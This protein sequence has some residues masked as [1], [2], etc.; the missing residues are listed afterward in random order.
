MFFCFK[1]NI[2]FAIQYYNMIYKYLSFI[3]FFSF[4]ISATSTIAQDRSSGAREMMI[5]GRVLEEDT[6]TPMEY[7]TVSLY[8][9]A[10]SSLISG[11]ITDLD[12]NFSLKTKT[13]KGVFLKVSFIGFETKTI[14]K[15]A[16]PTG[17]EGIAMGDIFLGAGANKVE[18][19]EVIASRATVRYELDKKIVDVSKNLASESGTAVDVLETVPSV[20]VDL[21]GNVSLRGNSNI[22]VLVNGQPTQLEASEALQQIPANN[23]KNI[24]IITNPSARFEA[25]NSA[26]IL[27]IILKEEKKLGTSGMLSL[28][29]GTF[30]QYGGSVNIKH[31]INKFSF[32]FSAFLR[33]GTRPNVASDSSYTKNLEEIYTTTEGENNRKFSGVSFNYTMGYEISKSQNISLGLIYGRW[34]MFTDGENSA[35]QV[36]L[37]RNESLFSKNIN[38]TERGAPYFGPS[39]TYNA[40]LKNKTTLTA[41]INFSQRDFRENVANDVFDINDVATGAS[42]STEEGLSQRIAA[43]IDLAIPIK[44]GKLE[45]GGQARNN[46]NNE[47]NENFELNTTSTVFEKT[48]FNNFSTAN[49]DFV[50]GL[51]A[52][53]GNKYKKLSYSAGLRAEYTD[54]TIFLQE[55][56]TSFNYFKWNYFPTAHLSYSFDE[57]QQI[58]GSYSTRIRRPRGWFLEPGFIKTG[59]N[60][61]FQG[62]PE[63]IPTITNSV[64]LGWTKTFKN[65]IRVSTEAFYKFNQNVMEIVT[66]VQEDNTT[67]NR[68]YNIGN[69]QNIGLEA[70]VS[71]KPLKFWEFDVMGTAYYNILKGSF[72]DIVFDNSSF[73][74]N[75]R[76][77]NFFNATKTT[78]IQFTARYNSRELTA[79]GFDGYNFG[80]D[81]GIKQSFLKRAL[82]LTLNARNIFNTERRFGENMANNFFNSFESVPRWPSINLAASYRINNYKPQ[83][84][85]NDNEGDF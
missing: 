70:N 12:G 32:D 66:Q 10:D 64:E 61:F 11:T 13:N 31:N 16:N 3:I 76:M 37:T 6:K 72:E 53:Y 48:D 44:E 18:A 63:I 9:I 17:P 34:A 41:F 52:S 1:Q 20:S 82:N 51:Y 4:T 40:T 8:Q 36:N 77:N 69:Q 14:S 60:S 68:P 15:I 27:N 39:L 79:L 81:L 47:V 67:L 21:D 26:G 78:K 57:T 50:Y 25:G 38:D 19:V 73:Q 71:V 23:I 85:Q 29:A 45:V 80:F 24:E 35:N 55:E 30:G 65:D 84:S 56:N 54:R 28:N 49:K 46:W 7:C 2:T 58:Y 83:R 33:S 22:L 5:T 62:N 43:K 59:V 42:L 75:L 74:W